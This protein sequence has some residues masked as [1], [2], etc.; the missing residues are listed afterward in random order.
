[1]IDKS[2]LTNVK[3]KA[4]GCFTARCPAC[5]K[6]GSDKSGNHLYVLEDGKFGCVVYPK[7]SG[8]DHR[9]RIFALVGIKSG[10]LGTPISIPRVCRKKVTIHIRSSQ[11]P[12]QASQA[13]KVFNRHGQEIDAETGFPII[14]GAIC[15]F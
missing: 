14:N 1:M 12:S 3:D 4:N 10:T 8:A 9:R 11:M 13:T 7:E 5:H 6:D 2:K 15:P